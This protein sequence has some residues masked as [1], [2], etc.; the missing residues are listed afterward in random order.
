MLVRPFTKIMLR[1]YLLQLPPAQRF[2]RYRAL[3]QISG[4]R[5]SLEEIKP[6]VLPEVVDDEPTETRP[7]L[8]QNPTSHYHQYRCSIG[9]P[10]SC[11][12]AE[13]GPRVCERCYFPAKLATE[14][15]LTGKQGTYDIGTSLGRRGIGRLYAATRLGTEQPVVVQEYLLPERY[16]SPAEQRQFQMAFYGLGGVGFG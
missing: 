16:F 4:L 11:P 15:Q 8:I 2:A 13:A 7:D 1:H 5:L 10:L 14:T 9:N 12:Q 3:L 6:E